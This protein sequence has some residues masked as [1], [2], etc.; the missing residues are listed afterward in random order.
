M[1]M[2]KQFLSLEVSQRLQLYQIYG[3]SQGFRL[4]ACGWKKLTASSESQGVP[5]RRAVRRT[6]DR[7]GQKRLATRRLA[8]RRSRPQLRKYFSGLTGTP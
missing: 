8:F 2:E 3:V 5:I 6:T 4:E 1:A 7:N